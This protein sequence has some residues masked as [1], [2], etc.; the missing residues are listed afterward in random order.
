MKFYQLK[1]K[2]GVRAGYCSKSLSFIKGNF[3]ELLVLCW[4]WEETRGPVHCSRVQNG[5]IWKSSPIVIYAAYDLMHVL[6]DVELKEDGSDG[7]VAGFSGYGNWV[8]DNVSYSECIDID[9]S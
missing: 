1:S 3:M 5:E 7:G 6:L 2:Y 4:T 8:D 9:P